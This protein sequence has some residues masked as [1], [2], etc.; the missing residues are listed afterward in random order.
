M[1]CKDKSVHDA[2]VLVVA[3][4]GADGFPVLEQ[5]G[6]I[7]KQTHESERFDLG[8]NS[9]LS[10]LSAG[11]SSLPARLPVAFLR[12]FVEQ[13]PHTQP[14][15]RCEACGLALPANVQVFWEQCPACQAGNIRWLDFNDFG[16]CTQAD[17]QQRT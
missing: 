10:M 9:W 4:A 17:H 8:F 13:H 6:F 2:L 14:I 15:Q 12:R 11:M 1:V 3:A 7:Q 5:I 16:L